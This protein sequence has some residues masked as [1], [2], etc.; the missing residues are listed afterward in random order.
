MYELEKLSE[1]GGPGEKSCT[2]LTEPHGL[3]Q[4]V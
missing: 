3:G 4:E 2:V 1:Q